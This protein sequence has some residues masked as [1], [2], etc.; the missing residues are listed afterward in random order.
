MKKITVV[1]LTLTIGLH[2]AFAQQSL[3]DNG[4]ADAIENEYRFDHAVDI[5]KIDVDVVDGIAELT[6][7]VDNL[8]AKERATKIARLV[9]GVRAVSNTISVNPPADLSDA[10][11]K[12]EVEQAFMFDPAADAY[13]VDVAVDKKTVTLTGAVD[14]YHEKALCEDIAKSV[15]GVVGLNSAI[16]V[17]YKTDRIDSEIKNEIEEVLRWDAMIDDGLIDVEVV[18]GEVTLEGVVGSAAEKSNAYTSAWVAG[19]RSVDNSGLKVQW[20][21]SDDDLRKNKYL[22]KND[23]EIEAAI[24]DA[25]LYDPRVYSYNISPEVSDGWVTLRGKVTNLKAKM[26]AEKLAENTVGV[27]GVTNRI[28]VIGE[29]APTDEEIE[30]DVLAALSKNAIT[31]P[32]E[33]TVHSNNGIVTLSGVVDSYL[34]KTEAKWVASGID[35]VTDVNNTLSVNYP[36]SYYWWGHYPYYELYQT[37]PDIT[38]TPTIHYPY[39]QEIKDKIENELWWSPYVDRD[40]VNVTVDNGHATLTGTVDSWREY[41]AAAENAYEAGAWTVVN[42]LQVQ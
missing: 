33:I 12:M 16:E 31:E 38:K 37:A 17:N 2:Y 7:T 39:D 20:W 10:A 11:I 23:N 5:N 40:Q 1:F 9:K 15:K 32:W 35:G 36:Y 29:L 13:E 28:K 4:I 26:A 24:E 27:L 41:R 34:E 6:G 18:D 14:S 3:D 8:K 22:P 42:K 25:A 30:W 21:A 19:V